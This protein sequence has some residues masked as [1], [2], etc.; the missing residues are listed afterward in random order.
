MAEI[1]LMSDPQ[2]AAVA[3]QECGERGAGDDGVAVAVDAGK[4]RACGCGVPQGT[5]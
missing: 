5:R 3:V 1:V 4:G 2:V